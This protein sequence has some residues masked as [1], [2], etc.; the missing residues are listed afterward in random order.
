MRLSGAL[1]IVTATAVVLVLAVATAAGADTGRRHDLKVYRAEVIAIEKTYVA[2]VDQARSTL[3]S[4]L[5]VAVTLGQRS[6]A[7]AQYTLAIVEATQA[8]DQALVNLG[9][10]PPGYSWG[11]RANDVTGAVTAT[12]SV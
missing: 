9:P 6:T 7:R 2:A 4:A 11:Q 1:R 5:S 3:A 10:P 12:V 8:R